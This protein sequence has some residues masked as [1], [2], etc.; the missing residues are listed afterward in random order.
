MKSNLS[1]HVF[2]RLFD[3]APMGLA[4]CDPDG[5]LLAV[6]EA[7]ASILGR[8]VDETLKLSYWNI[9]PRRYQ[10]Q[11]AELLASLRK[12]GM[13]GP[14]EKEYIH[15][16]GHLVPVRLTLRSIK[17]DG[18]RFIW[19]VVEDLTHERYRI[20]FRE[21]LTGLTLRR[22][23]GDLIAAN[24]AFADL[25]DRPIEELMKPG[26][27]RRITPKKYHDQED[28]I[29]KRMC[30][31]SRYGPYNKQYRRKDGD[32]IS[33][34]LEGVRLQIGDSQMI[35]SVVQQGSIE[36][37]DFV[38]ELGSSGFYPTEDLIDDEDDTQPIRP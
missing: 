17:V 28:D 4:L 12:T 6:N 26:L 32:L 22:M 34:A 25:V 37:A 18:S 36:D 10:A 13:Y 9:T 11:E 3:L 24:K 35:L 8:S 1:D 21:V 5:A 16:D 38:D 33:V 14:Y 30:L 23:D 27:Y 29:L 15:Q 31:D 7:Y 20:L 19:A 2:R